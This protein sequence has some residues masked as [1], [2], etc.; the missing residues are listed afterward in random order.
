MPLSANE[1]FD[2]L[3]EQ[4]ALGK[5]VSMIITGNSMSPFLEHG[6]DTIYF[7]KPD[8]KLRRGDMVFFQRENGK[9]V[10]HRLYKKKKNDCYFIGDNQTEIEGPLSEDHIFAVITKVKRKGRILDQKSFW[11]F[12]FA[13]VW[14]HLIPLRPFIISCYQFIF[15]K[16]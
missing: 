10:M 5:E 3:K 14:I 8:R 9:Y 15:R 16:K 11:W 12:F 4:V 1:Y 2:L 7:K 13:H 6:K